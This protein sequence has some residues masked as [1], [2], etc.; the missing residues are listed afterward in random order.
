M[1]GIFSGLL[2]VYGSSQKRQ[3]KQ[4]K[5]AGKNN[6][7][8]FFYS[9]TSNL[10]S[11][12][13]DSKTPQP[14]FQIKISDLRLVLI[15]KP[16]IIVGLSLLGIQIGWNLVS[17]FIVLY[18]KTDLHV[19]PSFA[20][21]VAGLAMILNIIFAPIFGRIY[22]RIANKDNHDLGLVL[23]V[24]CGIFVSVNIA[25]FSIG[26]IYG[27]VLS[28][29]MI[30]IFISGGFVVP[31][32]KAREMATTMLNQ[33]RYETLAVSFVNG[34]SLFGAFWVPFVFSLV[35]IHFGYPVAWLIGGILTLV[36]IL[37]V[38]KLAV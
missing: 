3:Q 34:L 13:K 6:L 25:L 24:V 11:S 7:Q 27:M 28:I 29:I 26:N 4:D 33:H 19:N 1:L 37:P 17:T 9:N 22:D 18:L 2:L 30:G 38:I 32:T 8:H 5:N 12:H 31:Y 14:A 23:L 21:M 20:G 35:V 16:M 15:N 10:R 36:F